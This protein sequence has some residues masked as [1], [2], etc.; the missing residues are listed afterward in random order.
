MQVSTYEIAFPFSD[1]KHVLMNGLYGAI[2]IVP[3]EDAELLTQAK[4]DPSLLERFSPSKLEMLIDRGHIVND[5]EQEA[6]D[7]RII[8][9]LH[10]L[11]V[12]RGEAG[13]V[14]IPT[15]NCNFRC[16][17][18]FEQH[19]LSRGQEWLE[20]TM[21]PSMLDDIFRQVKD[22]KARGYSVKSCSLYGGEPLLARN[23]DLIRDICERCREND[24]SVSA[25]TNGYD[26][27][28]FI[29]IIDEFKF[30][31]LQITVDGLKEIHDQQ[32]PF[33][34]GGNSY[35]KIMS[36]IGLALEHGINVSV[37]SNVTDRNIS[38]IKTLQEEFKSRGFTDKSC[39]RYYFRAV[40]DS[41]NAVSDEDVLNELIRTGTPLEEA[42]RLARVYFQIEE[43]LSSWLNKK[44]VPRLNPTFCGAE[45]GAYV[46]D[47]YGKIFSC[48]ELVGKDGEET[49]FID[50]GRFMYNFN[51][52]KWRTRTSDRMPKC[53][54]CPYLM[55]CG[56]GCARAGL[57][58]L[59]E[60]RC[61]DFQ[62]RFEF[63]APIV[64]QKALNG[65]YAGKKES[66]DED[67]VSKDRGESML[68]S[69][70]PNSKYADDPSCLSLS[71]REFLSKFNSE[72]RNILMTTNS[73]REAAD[74]L[75]AHSFN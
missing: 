38:G 5:L 1:D 9:R 29:D 10:T 20:H 60:G 68:S 53:S 4:N 18:C 59:M 22:F 50:G 71:V 55:L 15:Y 23:K 32:R 75:E 12:G 51:I 57:K 19:R 49:G 36:N 31:S 54:K 3:S 56:G 33:A 74:I 2:D 30:S 64:I 17:Y 46:I 27:D 8:S 43:G 34:G 48:W 24:M 13:I 62:K 63:V 42:I 69:S 65:D 70:E 40:F 35:D 28:S 39:F 58:H 44:I 25:V 45:N 52:A 26:L 73:E 37:R 72:E 7:L 11:I 61:D 16:V 14:L 21:T 66:R 47:P 41:D 6:Q 67:D